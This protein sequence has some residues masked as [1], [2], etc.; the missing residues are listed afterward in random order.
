MGLIAARSLAISAVK[1]ALIPRYGH[2]AR[3]LPGSRFARL[4]NWNRY[5]SSGMR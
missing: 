1:E 3:R 2:P 5:A 4:D